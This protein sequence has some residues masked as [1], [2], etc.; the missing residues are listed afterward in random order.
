VDFVIE[1]AGKLLPIEVE[2][3]ARPRRA[4]AAHLRTFR[5]E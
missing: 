4:D 3:T 5:T 1:T 2:M